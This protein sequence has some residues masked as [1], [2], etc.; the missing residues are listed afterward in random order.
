M[1]FSHILAKLDFFTYISEAHGTVSW[2]DHALALHIGM[3]YLVIHLMIFH[4]VIIF[5]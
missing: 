2:L 4:L 1:T 5:L 3:F